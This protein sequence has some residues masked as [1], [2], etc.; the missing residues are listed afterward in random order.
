MVR[1][2]AKWIV[3]VPLLEYEAREIANKAGVKI[4]R[5]EIPKQPPK[6]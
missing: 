3:S 4:V 1:D 6:K 2:G 5:L